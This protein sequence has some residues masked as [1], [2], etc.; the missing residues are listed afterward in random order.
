MMLE[1]VFTIGNS[2][3]HMVDVRLKIVFTLFFSFFIALSQKMEV[4]YCG[5]FCAVCTIFLARLPWL[6]VL[7]RLR[8]VN[9]FNL[10]F[11]LI[12]PLT[13]AGENT[14]QAALF[15]VP[16]LLLAL[17][18][19]LKSNAILLMFLAMIATSPFFV[20]AHALSAL[21]L[22]DKFVYL[23]MLTYRYIFVLEA[24]YKK[25][26]TAAKMRCFLAKTSIHTY[27]TYAYLFGMLLVKASLRGEKVYQAMLCRGFNGAFYSL[28]TFCFRQLDWFAAAVM[29]LILLLLIWL[30]WGG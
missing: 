10:L 7:R 1:E 17:Q 23:L 8:V 9:F 5:L 30:Q 16:G 18:I 4:L 13:L 24:E 3:C 19:T 28:H 2:L 6:E 27:K 14:P 29:F 15:G 12:L 11:W 20:V 21:H 25:L 22:P 26:A